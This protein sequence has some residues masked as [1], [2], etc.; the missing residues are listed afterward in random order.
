MMKYAVV[1]IK[2]TQ[3]KVSEG[4]EI[5]VGLHGEKEKVEP[6][7]LLLVNESKVQIGT[8]L[9]NKVKLK[10]KNLG[11]SKG[12]KIHINKFRAK[13]RYRRKIGFRPKYTKLLVQK[14][15]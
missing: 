14:I 13:S 4:E 12:V 8:P 1:R 10:L 15:G 3:Y 11:E 5:L 6:E 9:L 2:G 7:V